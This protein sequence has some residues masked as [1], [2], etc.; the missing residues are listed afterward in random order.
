MSDG[1][2]LS[3]GQESRPVGDFNELKPGAHTLEPFS[4][5]TRAVTIGLPTES[6]HSF[7]YLAAGD[8]WCNEDRVDGHDGTNGLLHT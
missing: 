6:V 7:H 1:F 3:N 4:D 8:C 5:G 2:V